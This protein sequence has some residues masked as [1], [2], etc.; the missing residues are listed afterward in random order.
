[1]ATTRM[2]APP[3]G[4]E[5]AAVRDLIDR[6]GVREVIDRYYETSSVPPSAG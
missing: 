6:A 3:A 5:A 4:A 1:M 2:R